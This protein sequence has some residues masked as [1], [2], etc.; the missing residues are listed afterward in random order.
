MS[1]LIW[2]GCN[3][4]IDLAFYYYIIDGKLVSNYE[5]FD[6]YYFNNIFKLIEK[7][8]M[9]I[10][11]TVFINNKTLCY[12]MF[13]CK[14]SDIIK[15]CLDMGIKLFDDNNEPLWYFHATDYTFSYNN[16]TTYFK[17]DDVMLKKIRN[18]YEGNTNN[19][20]NKGYMITVVEDE[21]EKPE[22]IN[23]FDNDSELKKLYDSI[24]DQ[25][26]K[27]KLIAYT[28]KLALKKKK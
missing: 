7:N 28:V 15:K 26:M 27:D 23:P 12:Y 3:N 22:V 13:N 4:E 18:V 6:E 14:N 16:L 11:T 9:N 17:D 20:S 1:H 19:T 10:N 8:L 21:E 24:T 25:K 2:N 5:G